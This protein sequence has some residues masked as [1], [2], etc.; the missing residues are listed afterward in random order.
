MTFKH[1]DSKGRVVLGADF[2]NEPLI[3]ELQADGSVLVKKAKV[4]PAREAWLYE[5]PRALA[6]VRQGLQ[7]ARARKFAKNP[8]KLDLSDAEKE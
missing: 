2:A 1:A 7:Q 3:V 4:I 8:V 6:A 5:N